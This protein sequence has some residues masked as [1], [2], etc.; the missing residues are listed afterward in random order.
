M[1]KRSLKLML[2]CLLGAV[3]LAVTGCG[4]PVSPT[5]PPDDP[6]KPE[7]SMQLDQFLAGLEE[8]AYTNSAL[9]D[10]VYG[11]EDPDNVG[12]RAEN[13]KELY[14]KR[15]DDEFETGTVFSFDESS[16]ETDTEQFNRLIAEAYAVNQQGKDVKIKFPDRTVEFDVNSSVSSD[17]YHTFTLSGFDGLWL[18]GGENTLLNFRATTAWKGAFAFNDCTDVQ[19]ND[20]RID[21]PVTPSLTGTVI[22]RNA[23]ARTVTVSLPQEFDETVEAFE[24]YPTLINQLQSFIEYD[25]LTGGPRDGGIITIASENSIQ[26]YTYGKDDSGGNTVTFTFSEGY[27]STFRERL[28]VIG[29]KI[30]FA[31]TMY[32]TNGFTIKNA[33]N[34][35][36]EN[37][38]ID[39]CPG[40]AIDINSEN[41]YLN[42]V[43]I[44]PSRGRLM[45]STADGMHM[46][47]CT[48]EVKITA[49]R[50]VGT[51]D[52]AVNVKSGYYY[53]LS[54]TF[55]Y[56]NREITITKAS[57]ANAM[58]EPGDVIEIYRR[59]NFE[60]VASTTVESCTGNENEYV[61]KIATRLPQADY[62]DCIVMNAS[63][64]CALTF[65]DNYVA[66]KRNRG[67]LVQT[68]NAVLE[69]NTFCNVGHGS[70][71]ICSTVS[72]FNEAGVP[73]DITVRNN[74]LIN[75]SYLGS[76][77]LAGDIAAF[78][79]GETG[80]AVAGTIKDVHIY[81]NYV[82]RAGM[83][84]VSLRAVGGDS[85]VRGNLFYNVAYNTT[86]ELMFVAVNLN[87]A[88]NIRIEGNY[89]YNTTGND[90]FSGIGLEGTTTRDDVTVT[91]DNVGMEFQVLD[92]EVSR[93]T[94]DVI[95]D[96]SIVVDGDVSDWANVGTDI[97]LVG[98]S[99]ATG[100]SI[101]PSEYEDVFGVPLRK[102]AF[103]DTGIYFGFEVR[104]DRIDVK[105]QYDFW[106]GDCIEL[107]FTDNFTMASADMLIYRNE[108]NCFQVALAPGNNWTLAVG[109][110]RTGDALIDTIYDEWTWAVTRTG[111]GYTAELYVP[112]TTLP[113][114]KES[115]AS[116]GEVG[117]AVVFADNDRDDINR[118]RL[119]IGNVP[120][121]VENW[122]MRT[123]KMPRYLLGA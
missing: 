64:C 92:G 85:Y 98:H 104:D 74:K 28:P 97:T 32:A 86:N 108:G 45:S 12:I 77:S 31:H 43:S 46:R 7:A 37:V 57:E 95:D 110:A 113:G 59:S 91:D 70:F 27:A 40:M 80:V 49:C 93:Y 90:A 84:A 21:Y 94:V 2:F 19:I 109:E 30:A 62:T 55:S 82:T 69:N 71:M 103:S 34:F 116:G 122:K 60:L 105:T 54:P 102:I 61:I 15:A 41:A 58:P 72:I 35:T 66:D 39:S 121:F 25:V 14:P 22:A 63:D 100:A 20:I 99:V 42:R 3:L 16:S 1:M 123:A 9:T 29:N 8:D 114:V 4:D 115:L 53:T 79:E 67:I 13:I 11:L 101:L 17:A 73:G 38:R 6:E 83:A 76:G 96:A 89:N 51:H 23:D 18:E 111:T 119:Q 44:E 36:F 75:N 65:S 10:T 106:T 107:F 112:F 120:H 78:A 81:N 68:R 117:I 88:E 24:T 52:D 5:L 56:I 48:G 47:A 26:S 50:I 33:E 87:N 118:T